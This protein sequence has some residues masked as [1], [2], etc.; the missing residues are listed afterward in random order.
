[1]KR[2]WIF[3]IVFLFLMTGCS[4]TDMFNKVPTTDAN[5]IYTQAAQTVQV[6]I[7]KVFLM[8]PS[9]TVT[10]TPEP[11][12]TETPTPLPTAVPTE[13][14]ASVPAGNIKAPILL[15]THI[16]D[17]K[18]D[19]PYYQNDSKLDI[20]SDVFRKQMEAFK[21]AGYETITVSNLIET[22]YNGGELPPKPLLITFDGSTTGIYKKAFPILKELGYIA[23]VYLL[24]G[25]MEGGGVITVEQAKELADAGWEIGSKGMYGGINLVND[26]GKTSQEAGLSKSTLEENLG[27][28]INIFSYPYGAMD[29]Q[30]ARKVS[31]YGYRGAVG[32]GKS[33]EHGLNSIFYLSRLEITTETTLDELNA[34]IPWPIESP[35]VTPTQDSTSQTASVLEPEQTATP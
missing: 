30:L 4:S 25:R 12:A 34:L 13:P 5:M 27:F 11:T 1:M 14:W 19:N 17:D 35:E 7:T 22:I 29:E 6:Q 32:L 28:P 33:V 8:T 15:Y 26:Y 21:N 9:A 24:A 2:A 31:Q 3:P 16:T 23:N 20:P 10:I 18:K